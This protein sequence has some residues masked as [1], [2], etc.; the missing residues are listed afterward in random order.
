MKKRVLLIP[1][2]MKQFQC[3]GIK[4]KDNCCYGWKIG[5]DENTYKKYKK[6]TKATIKQLINKNVTRNRSNPSMENYAKIKLQEN[7]C[8]PF[9]K[10]DKLCSIHKELGEEFL[11][12]TCMTYPRITNVINEVHEKSLL[13]SC[14]EAARLILLN[15]N[16]ME[17]DED[18]EP[19]DIRNNI[20][21]KINANSTVEECFWMLRIFS[22]SL[23][24]NR[25]FSLGDRLIILGLFMKNVQECLD[26][27][28]VSKVTA[29]IE[30][31]NGIMGNGNL[32]ETLRNIP[33]NLTIQME[34]MKEFNDGR[35]SIGFSKNSQSYIECV[36][37][38]LNGI[39]Y[40]I[41][42]KVE[43]VGEKYKKAYS[44]YYEPFMKEHEYI[45]ENFIV[46]YVFSQMFPITSKDGVFDAYM[47]LVINYSLCKM[48][49]IGMAAYNKKLDEGLIV[50]LV[51]SYSRAIEHNKLFFNNAFSLFKDNGYN[52]MAYMAILIKN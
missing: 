42:A 39:E 14:P 13:L 36:S 7:G 33:T 31:F 41:N 19:I 22:I 26:N 32:E 23:L 44:S 10:E 21:H 24:Q 2:Y 30:E 48:L 8:C 6:T 20:M 5:I 1:Q 35:F 50:R 16:K 52:T 37:E 12:K 25:Q 4:C 45:L 46:N 28:E 49:L 11:S 47:R 9:L 29:I 38:F 27:N 51:Y 15:P 17:F 18:E 40:T 34:L 3:I 43:E